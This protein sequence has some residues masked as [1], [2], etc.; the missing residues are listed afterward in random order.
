MGN[1]HHHVRTVGAHLRHVLAGGFGDVVNGDFAAQVG[2]I[3]G[4]DLRRHKADIAD[5]QRVLAAVFIDHVRFFNQ[6]RSKHRF[7]GLNVDD[8]GVNVREF[9][10]RQRFVQIIQTVVELV[11]AE[12]AHRVVEQVHR[13]IHRVRIALLQPFCCRVVA[14]WATLNNVAVIH[15]HAVLHLVASGVNQARR[16]DQA[17]LLGGGIF[18]VIKIHHIAMK[19]GGFHD[20]EVHRRRID[21]G[22]DQRGQKRCAK[23][24]HQRHPFFRSKTQ[25]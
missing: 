1:H 8:I 5:F 3:P 18:V 20:T 2:F 25:I 16:A 15:Q 11:V 7:L 22:G 6:I 17:E 23:L 19:I 12:V 9:R 24:D 10:T 14:H 4:H 21:A 13:F